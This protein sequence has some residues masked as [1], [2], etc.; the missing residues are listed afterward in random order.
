MLIN[1]RTI[2][3]LVTFVV[4]GGLFFFWAVTSL[5]NVSAIKHPYTM[6]AD[7]SNA[8][9]L[10]PGSEVDYLGVTYGTVS[11]VERID[12]GVRVT[13]KIDKDKKIP[14]NSSANIFRKSALGEQYIEFEPP[15]GYTNGGPY[16]AK[17]VT[18][19][20]ARTTVPL[21]FSELLRSASRL[22]S[23]IPPDAVNTLVHEAAVGVNGRT[24]SLRGLADAGD[25]LSQML[26]QRS[27]ALDRLATNNTRLTHVFTEHS[28]SFA[29]S[30]NDLR[31]IAD[32]LKN[33]RG[34]TTILLQRG[35]QL[36]GT[37]A[38]L[39]AKHK[40]DLDCDLKTL[41]LLT[42]VTTTNQNLQGLQTV[43]SGAPVA[44][45]DLWDASDVDPIPGYPTDPVA[46]V[47]RWVRVGFKVNFVNPAPQ[48]IPPRELP[49]VAEVPACVSP[50]HS[51]APD[52]VPASITSGP[53]AVLATTGGTTAVGVA[54]GL[55][56]A[57]LIL[58]ETF[59]GVRSNS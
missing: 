57:A 38:D 34:D 58:R 48:Y 41:E 26:V 22:V 27:S 21:E 15:A 12:G 46:P 29:S 7:F 43:L 13:M 5:V 11:G 30:V 16:Y 45:G 4:V 20:M 9:G 1:K 37:A 35:S 50:L 52:Y 10:L 24:D 40:A 19:P 14:D 55:M 51:N 53:S 17:N 56:A 44:F 32:S 39:V 49:P 42:D 54:L 6:K 59:K 2:A 31:N 25:K 8:V 33:A 28:D 47:K 18:I 36:L 3:N 23:A